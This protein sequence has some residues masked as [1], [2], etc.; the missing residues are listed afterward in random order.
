MYKNPR[1]RL[2]LERHWRPIRNFIK[3]LFTNSLC[4]QYLATSRKLIISVLSLGTTDN[5]A[6]RLSTKVS[7][8]HR[9]FK[10]FVNLKLPLSLPSLRSSLFVAR[11]IIFL[12]KALLFLID[13]RLFEYDYVISF[14]LNHSKGKT[15][16]W[17]P[18]I[19]SEPHALSSI[20]CFQRLN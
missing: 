15:P 4:F 13:T 5:L 12:L 7:P 20:N 19:F 1:I 11:N 10:M 6:R 3:I 2:I 17:L 16:P 9:P 18:F 8:V 14:S